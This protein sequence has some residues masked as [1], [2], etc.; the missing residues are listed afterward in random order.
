M[1]A[2]DANKAREGRSSSSSSKVESQLA[3]RSRSGMSLSDV[4]GGQVL[5]WLG[6]AATLIGM[7]LFLVLAV[8][9]GWIGQ[10]TRVLLAAVASMALM[11]TG[12]W[13][14]DRRG[15]TEAAI[16][17]V[18]T[19]TAGLFATLIVAS[20]VYKLLPELLAVLGAMLVGGVATVLAIRW[21][22]RAI[23]ALGLLGALCAGIVVGAPIHIA[24]IA[25]LAVTA[26]CATWVAVKQR[27]GWLALGTVLIC[28]PQLTIWVLEGWPVPL[29]ILVLAGFAALGLLGAFGAQLNATEER[30][31]PAAAATATLSACVVAFLGWGV[32]AAG[33]SPTAGILWLAALA[34]V[35]VAIGARLFPRTQTSLPL[36]RLLLA[37]GVMLADVAFAIGAHGMTLALG[38]SASAVMFAWLARRSAH[39]STSTSA[40]S[41]E[42]LYTLGVGAQIGIAL[43]QVLLD[44]PP[45]AFASGTTEPLGL[46]SIS[47]LAASCIACGHLSASERTSWRVALNSLGLIAIAYLSASALDGATLVAAW[48]LEGLALARVNARK[49]DIVSRYGACAFIGAAALHT[50]LV[51]A[52]PTAL[53]SGVA[54]LGAAAG[55]LGT[56]AAVGV[57]LGMTRT[58][59]TDR[60]HWPLL[61][62]AGALLYLAS[63]A[64]I[65][66]FTPTG[67]ATSEALLELSVR[68]QGQVALSALWS[69]L[70]L[71]A[72]ILGLR[73]D[74][75]A[76]RT[77]GLVLL[78]V[79]VAKVFLYD[80]ST[81][82]SLYRVTSFT[83]LGLLL[84]SGALAYQRLR[85]PAP[86]DMRTVHP[87]QL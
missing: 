31:A 34:C 49:E 22:G 59:N 78:L 18:G 12:I 84:L 52:P 72:L 77:A 82:T 76:V 38:W 25:L 81:L 85:P 11:G 1:T 63:V 29:E 67:A 53:S 70:G 40:D 27:W 74:I 30:L 66:A 44:A 43:I 57:R 8:S 7:L 87:S 50:L 73:R 42:S 71:C 55:A 35:H 16:A 26:T 9:H 69:L 48:A 4:I 54:N 62:A 39:A 5:A 46:L 17:M 41:N 75:P 68:Q 61:G 80:L 79:A 15:R 19:A 33:D 32:L 36:Q 58:V 2:T 45:S 37:L 86:P 51:E 23:G 13:L 3:W 83:V 14:H 28:A 47:A 65:T 60:R 64:T 10:E 6:G 24:S 21:A 56:L 20:A